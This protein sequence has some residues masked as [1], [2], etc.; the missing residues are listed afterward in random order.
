MSFEG[1]FRYYKRFCCL[2]LIKQ[3][4][5]KK[6]H[7]NFFF[8]KTSV[9][10]RCI[11]YKVNYSG[12]MSLMWTVIH[13]VVRPDGLWYHTERDR[14]PTAKFLVSERYAALLRSLF[15]LSVRLSACL[16]VCGVYELW[17]KEDCCRIYLHHA[18]GHASGSVVKK[19]ARI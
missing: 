15:R 9:D 13:T 19:T 7:K 3:K 4:F 18:V 6:F 2:Y 16:F 12:M 10:H 11:M 5:H 8:C 14:L 17:V 1:H